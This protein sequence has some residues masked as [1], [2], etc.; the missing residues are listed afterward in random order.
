MAARVWACF[1]YMSYSEHFKKSS[2]TQSLAGFENNLVHMLG[3]PLPS[4]FNL[5]DLL[6]DMATREVACFPYMY[7]VITLK[8]IEGL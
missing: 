2:C 3:E 7:R 4:L 5:F 1:P 8:T 6:I